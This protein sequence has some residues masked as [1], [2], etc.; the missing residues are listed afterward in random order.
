MGLNIFLLDSGF[1]STNVGNVRKPV[2]HLAEGML[3]RNLFIVV[4]IVVSL[5]IENM[6]NV[7]SINSQTQ[8]ILMSVYTF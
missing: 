6:M 5:C 8:N 3:D 2:K 4:C 7:A 1:I